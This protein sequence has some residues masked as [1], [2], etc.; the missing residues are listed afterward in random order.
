M[1]IR[2]KTRVVKIGNVLIGGDN[3]VI[4]QSMAKTDTANISA[5][6][7]EIQGLEASGCEIVRVAVKNIE[8]ALAIR[9]I[10][11]SIE[12]PIV[13]DI[14]FD[15]RLALTAINSGADKIRINP[16][17]I[18]KEK[19]LFA[20]I[21]AARDKDIP[22]RVG[23]N[24]GSLPEYAD[25]ENPEGIKM[26]RAA[27][28]YLEYFEKNKFSNLVVSLKA[29]NVLTTI[30]AYK[31]MSRLS[32]YPL[33]LG[34]TAAGTIKDAMVRS[35]I[36]IG[37]LLLSGIGDTI[38]VSITGDARE[39]I[40]IARKILAS[41][42]LRTFGPNLISCPTCGRCQ[43]DLIKITEELEKALSG[44]CFNFGK[45]KKNKNE[46]LTEG[47][48]NFTVAV[49]GCEVNGPGEA[50]SA[51]IGIAFGKNQGAIFQN[52]KIFKI[53]SSATAVHELLEI[54]KKEYC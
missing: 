10:K 7:R 39:E 17:N 24:S 32:E 12:I 25:T 11:K 20:V 50:K 21:S 2:A 33:H 6:I 9:E 54:I 36:G 8:S 38:R 47:K 48:Q 3:P 19:E 37:S 41:L 45:I 29:S 31:E 30:S 43:V 40:D 44:I 5:T 15:Y 1:I 28:Q 53:V 27:L 14:H 13:A 26:A 4:I 23:V 35:S 18:F 34:I 16:G 46:C 49:M 52:G 51:D 22:I 42:E